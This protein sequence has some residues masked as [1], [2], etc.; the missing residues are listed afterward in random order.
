MILSDSFSVS[1]IIYQERL[2]SEMAR[3]KFEYEP[4]HNDE[5]RLGEIGQLITII[6]KDCGDAGWFE[7]EINGRRGL[8]PDNFVELVQVPINTRSGTIYHQPTHH[9][10]VI[11]K[12]PAATPAGVVPPAVPAKPLKQKLSDGCTSI[13]GASG[14]SPPTSNV[15]TAPTSVLPSQVKQQ[16]SA[17]AAARDRI[18]KD[19]VVGQPGQVASKLTKSVIVTSGS[20]SIATAR[21]VSNIETDESADD[22][23][24][25]LSHVTKN[26]VRPPGKRPVS[27]LIIKKRGSTDNLIESPTHATT[28]DVVEKNPFSGALSTS[29]STSTSPTSNS[30]K[31]STST[32]SAKIL[33]VRPPPADVKKEEKRDHIIG[34]VKTSTPVT[35]HSSMTTSLSSSVDSEWVSRKEY[36]E[37]L[38]RLASLEARVAQLERR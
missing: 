3:V 5:L 18:S 11:T 9:P 31:T 10:K 32:V 26:R 19:L 14:T 34:G 28:S 1:V 27:M 30:A 29:L 12:A 4:Q 2:F 21:P 20:E 17:F 6:R 8:F 15:T 35:T 25:P 24:K 13:N 36:N 22:V 16:N 23:I 7:G 38:A 37:L 33:P